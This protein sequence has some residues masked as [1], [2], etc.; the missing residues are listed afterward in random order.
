MQF[1]DPGAFA[2]AAFFTLLPVAIIGGAMGLPVLMCLAGVFCLRPSVLRQSIEKPNLSILLLL[3][4]TAWA[5]LSANWSPQAGQQ[6]LKLFILVPLGLLFASA[7]AQ[8]PTRRLTIAGAT[9]AFAV[10]MPLMAIEALGGLPF[11]RA[12][13]P[14]MPVDELGRNLA[15]AITMVISMAWPVA[16]GLLA[17]G[18][19]IR[20]NAARAVLL[21]AA[22]I[23]TQGGQLASLVAFAAGI[24]AFA[25]AYAAPRFT[26]GTLSFGLAGWVLAAPF[27]TPLVLSNQRLVDALPLSWAARAGI[28]EYVCARIPE[29]LL[30]GHG[31]DASRTIDDRILVRGIDM[32]AVPVHPHSASL[33]LWYETGAIGAVLAALL[34]G[35]CGWTLSRALA[36]NR[37]AAAAAA[38]VLASLGVIANVSYGLW[39][40]WWIACMFLAAALVGAIASEGRVRAG[41]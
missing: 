3:A 11:N 31:L 14:D 23:A 2:R 40:E 41:D 9:A 26:V 1:S 25:A 33:Q 28:W 30:T 12:A 16:A 20:I 18:G 7:A 36:G 38:G 34:L 21:S 32:N 19:A 24:V 13:Q 5:I 22:L 15:R 17:G 4:L 6:G 8:A 10:V 29:R 37:N 35:A 39:A 27:A